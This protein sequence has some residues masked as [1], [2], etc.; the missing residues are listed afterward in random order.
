[1]RSRTSNEGQE[2]EEVRRQTSFTCI[3]GYFDKFIGDYHH[4]NVICIKSHDLA[5]K[6]VF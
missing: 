2:R 3:W 6:Y 1:M 4:L 5:C